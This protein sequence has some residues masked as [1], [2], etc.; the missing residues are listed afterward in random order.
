MIESMTKKGLMCAPDMKFNMTS[1]DSYMTFLA[2]KGGI[3]LTKKSISKTSAHWTAKHS[4]IGTLAL[5][6]VVASTHF[7]V[8]ANEDIE[9]QH[10]F[11][12]LPE[13]SKLLNPLS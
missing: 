1:V 8:V 6:I 7:Y 9:W 13:D 12:K 5:I 10:L 4:S 11:N 3:S 2:N